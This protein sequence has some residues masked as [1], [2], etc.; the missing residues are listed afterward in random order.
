MCGH[1]L[2]A[3]A[4]NRLHRVLFLSTGALMSQ[5]T[6]LQGESIPGIAHLL[7]LSS[8]QEAGR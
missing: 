8:E 5:T 1:V 3:L 7:E 6:F 2:G 4:E